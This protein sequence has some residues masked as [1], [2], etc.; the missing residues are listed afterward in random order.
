MNISWILSTRNDDYGGT[1]PG[2]ENF[3]MTRLRVTCKSIRNIAPNDEVI[4]VEYAPFVDRE[5]IVK[6]VSDI[7]NIKVVTVSP[8]LHELLRADADRPLAFYEYVAKTIG[9]LIAKGDYFIFCNPDNLFL[10][11][12]FKNILHGLSRNCVVRAKRYNIKRELALNEDALIQDGRVPH[13]SACR[14]AVGDFMGVSREIYNVVGGFKMLHA[15]WYLDIDFVY[16]AIIRGFEDLSHH[17]TRYYHYHID[18][19]HDRPTGPW[20]YSE[21]F[22]FKPI[23]PRLVERFLEFAQ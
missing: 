19:D 1:C 11:R 6:F 8:K 9:A 3:T 2:V 21:I 22:T 15:K 18:H 16:F 23:S 10:Q 7:P 12:N 17:E 4:V 13:F 5:P 20:D 14:N